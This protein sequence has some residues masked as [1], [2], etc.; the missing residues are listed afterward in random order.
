MGKKI[1]QEEYDPLGNLTWKG[2][3]YS[4]PNEGDYKAYDVVVNLLHKAS[5]NN[6]TFKINFVNYAQEVE[7]DCRTY[8]VKGYIN[9]AVEIL[10]EELNNDNR[11]IAIAMKYI[12]DNNPN[13]LKRFKD[14]YK[15]QYAQYLKK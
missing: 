1:Q 14:I 3:I 2:N 10:G 15:K 6:K 13:V 7:G 5:G 11:G 4:I 8:D 12:I 9:K